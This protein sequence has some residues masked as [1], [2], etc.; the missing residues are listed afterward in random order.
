MRHNQVSVAPQPRD[1]IPHAFHLG[2]IIPLPQRNH[3]I[4]ERMARKRLQL[5]PLE[6]AS[7]ERKRLFRRW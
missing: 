1:A 4:P 7:L 2:R 5:L 3:P 6:R